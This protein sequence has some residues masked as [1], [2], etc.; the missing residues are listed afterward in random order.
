M[1][2]KIHYIHLDTV[3]STNTYAKAHAHTFA[4]PLTCITAKEQTAGRGRFQRRWVSPRGQNIYAT[5]VFQVAPGSPYLSNIGQIMTLS[6]AQLLLSK[7]IIS[8]IKWPNDIVVS[9]KKIGGVLTETTPLQEKISVAV[10]IGL[11]VNMEAALLEMI[12]QPATSLLQELGKR[13]DLETL[14]EHLMQ[15][16]LTNLEILEK[17]GF[18]PFKET[19]EQ[20]LAFRG[21]EITC[22]DGA[23][24][25][26]GICQGITQE[27][28]LKVL[29][30]SGATKILLAG[31]ISS[32]TPDTR[33]V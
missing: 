3:D 2:K 8:E 16:F 20:L 4:H 13:E 11:N 15:Q 27:G 30:P 5:L 9:G 26:K 25:I 31:E 23:Q 6:C 18:A 22:H 28:H 10:G 7:G 33:P 14:L 17:S 32:T 24:T 1:R 19:F 12:D 29:L 21:Q